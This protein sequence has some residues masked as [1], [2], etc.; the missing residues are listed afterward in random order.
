MRQKYQSNSLSKKY[1]IFHIK[2]GRS[3][4]EILGKLLETV[5]AKKRKQIDDESISRA[6][7]QRFWLYCLSVLF[8]TIYWHD[9]RKCT[10]PYSTQSV[11][12]IKG[13]LRAVCI[14]EGVVSRRFVK[15]LPINFALKLSSNIFCG[16]CVTDTHSL[17]CEVPLCAD[18]GDLL[19]N[20]FITW[21]VLM[22]WRSWN[23]W[24]FPTADSE[25]KW[26]LH[27][28]ICKREDRQQHSRIVSQKVMM[29]ARSMLQ[30]LFQFR[31]L[32]Q[33]GE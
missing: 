25:S 4:H 6:W 20:N 7:C 33:T 5:N 19:L 23:L 13:D 27:K 12:W 1:K 22:L 8:T 18:C 16:D 28:R 11:T 21:S 26:H 32:L 10:R 3:K 30:L 14:R 24:A 2:Q 15:N 17:Y 31:V 9:R 29:I